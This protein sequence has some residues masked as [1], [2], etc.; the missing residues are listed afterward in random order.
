M[1]C[2]T[3]IEWW[4]IVLIAVGVLAVLVGLGWLTDW[5]LRKRI[6]TA[7]GERL[8]QRADTLRAQANDGM[9]FDGFD[10]ADR[11]G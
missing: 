2:S 7:V 5:T 4:A 8:R 9:G 6:S 1:E 11:D 3:D 10:E